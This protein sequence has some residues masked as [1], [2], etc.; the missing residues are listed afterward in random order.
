[1]FTGHY[2]Q[3]MAEYNCW[4]NERLYEACRQLGDELLKAD[5]GAFFGSIH[6]TLNHIL[7]GDRVW[8]ARFNGKTYDVK[9]MGEPLYEDF[10]QLHAARV[11]MDQ[12]FLD[13]AAGIDQAWLSEP[14]TWTSKLYGMSQTVPRWILVTQMFN[15]QTHHRGQI[16]TLLS[17]LGVDIGITDI[18]MLP[19]LNA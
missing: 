10:S 12:D 1:M 11:A 17:Q 2:P 16:S 9:A 4:M 13:W 18:P 19:V 5:R 15:H 7:W 6:H 3:L 14:M 8:L